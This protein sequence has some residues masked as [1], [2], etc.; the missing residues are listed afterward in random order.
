[1]CFFRTTTYSV[2]QPRTGLLE[3]VKVCYLSI[4]LVPLVVLRYCLHNSSNKG[5]THGIQST[6][7]VLVLIRQDFRDVVTCHCCLSL[8]PMIHAP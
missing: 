7:T 4:S 5:G 2:Q 3:V 1:M 6:Y 8:L